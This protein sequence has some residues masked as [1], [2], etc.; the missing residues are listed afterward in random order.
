MCRRRFRLVIFAGVGLLVVRL[1]FIFSRWLT[2]SS[3]A[4]GVRILPPPEFAAVTGHPDG[5]DFVLGLA[6]PRQFFER[7]GQLA[8]TL[9]PNN[10]NDTLLEQLRS[11]FLLEDAKEWLAPSLTSLPRLHPH[12][13]DKLIVVTAGVS[14]E[15]WR[16]KRETFLADNCPISNCYLMADLAELPPGVLRPDVVLYKTQTRF[17]NTL[18][19]GRTRD[20]IWIVWQLES[21]IS[22]P[23]NELN[24]DQ[25]PNWT[26]SYRI[27]STMISPYG[28]Y[29]T[30]SKLDQYQLNKLLLP[31][32][33]RKDYADGK[34]KMVAWFVSNCQSSNQRE[35]YVKELTKYTQVD[36]YGRC[37]TV[38]C[39]KADNNCNNM[40]RKDYKFYLAFENSN[41]RQYITEKL[42]ENAYRAETKTQTAAVQEDRMRRSL[43]FA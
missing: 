29:V 3:A 34:T 23:M 19:T 21:P 30:S 20:E 13:T 40:L 26:A 39:S 17:L 14:V 42:F 22:A 6:E 35:S 38:A 5:D 25:M 7:L 32:T 10:G 11:L 28:K 36:L 27:D 31:M 8:R 43:I 33:S 37:G 15:S 24:P 16:L 2:T 12:F 41:C 9:L 18:V 1:L 4:T